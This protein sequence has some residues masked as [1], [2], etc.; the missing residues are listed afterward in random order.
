MDDESIEEETAY[1]EAGHA[2]MALY[3]GGRVESISIAPDDD[4]GPARYG[5]TQVR[6]TAR[7][8]HQ[9]VV[10]NS[11]LVCLAGPVA[12]MIY[13][14][15]PLH[16][17]FV[18]EWADDWRQAWRL[19]EAACLDETKRLRFL[20]Q[21]TRDVYQLLQQDEVWARLARIVDHLLAYERLTYDELLD[22]I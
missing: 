12:E 22:W 17:G 3:L 13:R 11:L 19:A 6:W 20:E 21:L 1:H 7:M 8:S 10:R 16:P 18:P 2:W 14:H 9:E 15:E 4:D 5:D